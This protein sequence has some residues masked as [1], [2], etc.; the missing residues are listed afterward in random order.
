MTK[1]DVV[2]RT[3]SIT[4]KGDTI[5][6]ALRKAADWMEEEGREHDEDIDPIQVHYDKNEDVWRVCFVI[7]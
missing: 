1:P 3:Q 7:Q 2:M 5:P 4:F 6:E